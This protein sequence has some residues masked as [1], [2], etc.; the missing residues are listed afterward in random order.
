VKTGDEHSEEKEII[1]ANETRHKV[2]KNCTF[3]SFEEGG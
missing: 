3:I 2:M 1:T